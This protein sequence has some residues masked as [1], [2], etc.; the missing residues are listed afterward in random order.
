MSGNENPSIFNPNESDRL[1]ALSALF[2]GD[3]S[4]DM[5][6]AISDMKGSQILS[7]CRICP[8]MLVRLDRVYGRTRHSQVRDEFA[9]SR[10]RPARACRVL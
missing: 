4:I 7:A 10:P 1:L 5:I 8:V 9:G 3:F 2:E 6:M